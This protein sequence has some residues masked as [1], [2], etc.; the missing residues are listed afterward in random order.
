MR[1]SLLVPASLV[2]ILALA[3]ACGGA[4]PEP[5]TPSQAGSA[6]AAPAASAAPTGAPEEVAAPATWSFDLPKPQAAAYM[7]KYVAPR[8]GKAFQAHDATKYAS[9]GCKT[10]HGPE[11]KVPKDFLPKLTMQGGKLTAFADKPEV[12]KF[13]HEVVVPEMAAALG[14]PPY[15]P[16]TQ[17]GF[18]C[19]GCHSVDM[20]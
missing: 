3:A 5:T 13:M 11:Y 20:K 12:A 15:D 6:S 14:Q 7:K 17:K 10:C 9:F 1:S 2:S 8:L 16:A 19:T 18:G 4:S